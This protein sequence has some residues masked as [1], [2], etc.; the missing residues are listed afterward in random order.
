MTWSYIPTKIV[1]LLGL[2]KGDEIDFEEVT[3]ESPVNSGVVII[4]K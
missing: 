3:K 4:K 2:A 1:K